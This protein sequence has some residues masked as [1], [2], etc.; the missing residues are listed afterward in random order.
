M[1][2]IRLCVVKW[3]K[4][5]PETDVLLQPE[6][7]NAEVSNDAEND[8]LDWLFS[9]IT[10]NHEESNCPEDDEDLLRSRWLI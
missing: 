6:N 2:K 5:Q 9:N 4:R 3:H 1:E 7:V 8:D 10:H